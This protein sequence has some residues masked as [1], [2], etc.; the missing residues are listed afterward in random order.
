MVRDYQVIIKKKIHS[1]EEKT[2]LFHT[3]LSG[4]LINDISE[5]WINL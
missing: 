1:F 4:I 2:V 3:S 5:N